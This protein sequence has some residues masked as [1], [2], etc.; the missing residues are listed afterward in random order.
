MHAVWESAWLS[1]THHLSHR[2]HFRGRENTQG[3]LTHHIAQFLG[4]F[5][6]F[7]LVSFFLPAPLL[8]LPAPSHPPTLTPSHPPSLP[9]PITQHKSPESSQLYS[10]L[11]MWYDTRLEKCSSFYENNKHTRTSHTV[12]VMKYTVIDVALFQALC[13]HLAVRMAS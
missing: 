3:V 7:F 11:C 1:T 2:P 8:I 12:T 4:S 6:Q 9:P 10:G 13:R 5:I